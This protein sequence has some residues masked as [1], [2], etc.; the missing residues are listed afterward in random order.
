MGNGPPTRSAASGAAAPKGLV[1]ERVDVRGGGRPGR[2]AAVAGRGLQARLR[3]NS[4]LFPRGGGALLA[5]LEEGLGGRSLRFWEATLPPL[6][7]DDQYISTG[8]QI[9]ELLVGHDRIP[10]DPRPQAFRKLGLAS[11]LV[12]H[13]YDIS[14]GVAASRG[15]RGGGDAEGTQLRGCWT[16]PRPWRGWGTPTPDWARSGPP[17]AEAADEGAFRMSTR[18]LAPGRVSGRLDFLGGVADYSGSLV[19]QRP[20]Q[21]VGLA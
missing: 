2:A 14:Y 4:P 5:Q 1:A 19:S 18:R 10:G 16:R 7:F 9:Y 13:P 15:G 3:L 20:I 8:G 17:R 21:A 11:P 6:V 12:C